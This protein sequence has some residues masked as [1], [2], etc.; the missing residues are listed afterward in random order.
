MELVYR[1]DPM[2]FLI[3]VVE[4]VGSIEL[5]SFVHWSSD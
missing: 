3:I 4:G 2:V 1:I 5:V